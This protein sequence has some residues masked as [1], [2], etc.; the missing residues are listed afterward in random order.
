MTLYEAAAVLGNDC[1]LV[2]SIIQ[3]GRNEASSTLGV[4]R[5]LLSSFESFVI[6]TRLFAL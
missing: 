5:G 6:R 1:E 3:R 2:K 4:P